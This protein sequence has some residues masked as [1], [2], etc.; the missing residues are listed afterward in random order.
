MNKFLPLLFLAACFPELGRFGSD[1]SK[2]PNNL[3]NAP[4]AQIA[5]STSS[6]DF[7]AQHA[8]CPTTQTI[9]VTNEGNAKLNISSIDLSGDSDVFGFLDTSESLG[10]GDSFSLVVTFNAVAVQDYAATLT[11][12]SNDPT[13]TTTQVSIAGEGS[14]FSIVTDQFDQ[15]IVA[16]ADI[17]WVVDNSQSMGIWHSTLLGAGDE[18]FNELARLGVDYQ[19]GIVTTDMV[20]SAQA[21]RFQGD[22][23]TANE[24]YPWY[25]VSSQ[26]SGLG[27][28]G[29]WE[30]EHLDAIVTALSSP[31]IDSTNDGFARTGA[32]LSALVITMLPVS[33]ISAIGKPT[34]ARSG[35]SLNP[36]SAK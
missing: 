32:L 23:V 13:A 18:Y 9:K 8:G 2:D 11:I 14:D 17:L 27:I 26:V 22:I 34:V 12:R 4:Y 6:L 20:D 21:G 1:E 31:L 29:S 33:S 16:T 30:E 10:F 28:E 15:E 5:L 24:S 35:T 7:G 25:S 36:G 19:V 3:P